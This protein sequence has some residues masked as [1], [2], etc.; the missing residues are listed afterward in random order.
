MSEVLQSQPIPKVKDKDAEDSQNTVILVESGYCL[1]QNSRN[2]IIAML[3]DPKSPID[4]NTRNFG[5]LDYTYHMTL[6]H[7]LIE[8][9]KR[10]LNSK[11]KNA[12][13]EKPLQLKELADLI[14][15]HDEYFKKLT[16]GF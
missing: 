8:L 13:K 4:A 11:L 5:T 6:S 2:Y 14:K 16:Q 10:L 7:A 3:K 15:A 9:S 12:C 1:M